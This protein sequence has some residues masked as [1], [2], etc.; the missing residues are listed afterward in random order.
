M[1][2]GGTESKGCLALGDPAAED[3]FVL[4]ALTGIKNVTMILAPI[5]FRKDSLGAL[6]QGAPAW[7]RQ[8]YE[9]IKLALLRYQKCSRWSDGR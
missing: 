9:E 7:S 3:L 5:D 4:A 6:P 2:H 1:I 8:L